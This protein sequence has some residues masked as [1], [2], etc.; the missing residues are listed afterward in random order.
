M[1]EQPSDSSTQTHTLGENPSWYF[2]WSWS[3][4][5]R[6]PYHC[7]R[8][9]LPTELQPHLLSTEIRKGKEGK[10]INSKAS[11]ILLNAILK[12]PIF[13]AVFRKNS[14]HTH[15]ETASSKKI[16]KERLQMYKNVRLRGTLS[17]RMK[18]YCFIIL[19][20]NGS[21]Q[22]PRKKHPDVL[23]ST[24]RTLIR[25]RT[26]FPKP[27]IFGAHSHLHPLPF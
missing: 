25:W 21:F 7:E 3:G 27:F 16:K 6:R 2:W 13:F 24:P 11:C 26:L 15:F 17:T 5:N 9:A 12:L 8:Y 19:R 14:K 1:P 22:I 4:S 18:I 20:K 10:K 23:Q